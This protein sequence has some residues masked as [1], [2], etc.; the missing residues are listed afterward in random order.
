MNG[1]LSDRHAAAVDPFDHGL[2]VGDGI[3]ETVR[4]AAGRPVLLDRHLDRMWGAADRIGLELAAERLEL[5]RAVAAV[6]AAED[7]TSGRVRITATSG[8]GPAGTSR[9]V[10]A[11][12]VIVVAAPEAPRE[13]PARVVVAP[14][15]R[16]ERSAL[17]GVK[18]TS[19]GENV[20]VLRHARDRGAD[21]ALLA[22]TTGRLS[23]AAAANVVVAVDGAFVTPSLAAGCLPGIVRQVLLY[24][25][26]VA[27]ADLP[28][29][30]VH[31]ADEIAL[32]SS[33]AGVV[34]VSHVGE[35]SLG[36][37][38]GPLTRLAR[39]VLADAEASE[40]TAGTD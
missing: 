24:R 33:I 7:V 19:Y 30:V 21:E 8:S 5:V 16:N 27:E 32:T 26:V 28:L 10:G 13:G 37:V 9:A 1:R 4:V 6:I 20:L 14:W 36:G 29:A 3:F 17:A 23:E 22:D 40:G 15:V 38:D 25:G 39:R 18:S 12:T 35:R 11:G 2:T 34:A 31:D